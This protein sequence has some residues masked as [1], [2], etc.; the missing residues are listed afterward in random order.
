M[1]FLLLMPPFT[2]YS[3]CRDVETKQTEMPFV[4]LHSLEWWNWN[5]ELSEQDTMACSHSLY[6]HYYY[7][8]YISLLVR[9]YH[10]K[11]KRASRIDVIPFHWVC[12]LRVTKNTNKNF[13]L[14]IVFV[15][16]SSTLVWILYFDEWIRWE[17]NN[18][19]C[20]C[21]CSLYLSS[22]SSSMY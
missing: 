3:H 1:R 17:W 16:A 19:F 8:I 20:T 9:Y 21:R 14:L 2:K 5:A 11:N 18:I 15:G 4:C 22:S 6:Y 10:N 12:L 7:S 13:F